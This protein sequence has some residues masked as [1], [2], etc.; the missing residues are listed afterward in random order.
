MRSLHF[1]SI[2]NKAISKIY[3]DLFTLI[4][5]ISVHFIAFSHK[6]GVYLKNK[7]EIFLSF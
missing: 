1:T 3:R 4:M 2:L 5:D 7:M 6:N